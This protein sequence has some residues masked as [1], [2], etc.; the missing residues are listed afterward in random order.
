MRERLDK[1]VLA[2]RTFKEGRVGY[3]SIRFQCVG[4][5]PI[6]LQ[7]LEYGD[8][9]VPIGRYAI[10]AEDMEP[11]RKH[12]EMIFKCDE[13]SMTMACSRLA[14]SQ[15]R[16]RPEDRLVDAV[17]GLESLLLG[18]LRN[19]DRR[20]ELKFRFSLHYSTLFG[21]PEERY[22][23]FRLAKDLYDLR[24]VI[25]H[26]TKPSKDYCRLGDMQLSLQDASLR[27]C[28][29]LRDLIRHFLPCVAAT[30][31]KKPQFWERAYFGLSLETPAA[32][33]E[34]SGDNGN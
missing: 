29:V 12:A 31:Y 26:G 19:E 18:G 8:L 14:D 9:H 32:R 24:S 20:G 1:A 27:A 11:L 23:A 22:C 5:C 2:L 4:F 6:P 3:D 7:S 34:R 15:I 25:A 28:E 17:I 10:V 33:G 21:T 16:L 13:S 30:S